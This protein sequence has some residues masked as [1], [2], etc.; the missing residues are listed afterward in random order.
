MRI[1]K[2]VH[3]FSYIVIVVYWRVCRIMR[4]KDIHRTVK[5]MTR[6]DFVCEIGGFV[7]VDSIQHSLAKI[8]G[9][10]LWNIIHSGD[11]KVVFC[12]K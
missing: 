9:F 6:N 5:V 3:D 4:K 7:C 8:L 1:L 2:N 11:R 12:R 10:D